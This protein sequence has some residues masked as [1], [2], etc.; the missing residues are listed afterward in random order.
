MTP[1]NTQELEKDKFRRLVIRG[2]SH[3]YRRILFS[4]TKRASAYQK[5]PPQRDADSRSKEAI[6]D[7][8]RYFCDA[9]NTIGNQLNEIGNEIYRD[10]LVPATSIL[11]RHSS[12]FERHVDELVQ[13]ADRY[14]FIL[15]LQDDT[16]DFNNDT[17]DFVEQAKRARRQILALLRLPFKESDLQLRRLNVRNEIH[18]ILSDL[19][20]LFIEND[21]DPSHSVRINVESTIKIDQTLFTIAVSNLLANSVVHARR[22]NDLRITISEADLEALTSSERQE[23]LDTAAENPLVL[24]FSDN[25]PGIAKEEQRDVFQLFKQ[26]KSSIAKNGTGVGLA[27]AR[28]AVELMGG[29]LTIRDA[30]RSGAS[31]LLSVPSRP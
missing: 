1:T 17:A 15:S 2:L 21:S 26:G 28:L 30:P 7:T 31:F 29:S 3:D 14:K 19:S 18:R 25:G 20:A 5:Q 12:A 24:E 13:T 16:T 6:H 8:Y 10:A 23:V 22:G 27:F 4:L 9:A 11:S